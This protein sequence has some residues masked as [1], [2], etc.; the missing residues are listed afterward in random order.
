[1]VVVSVYC[2]LNPAYYSSLTICGVQRARNRFRGKQKKSFPTLY[3][4][5]T[6][7]TNIFWIVDECSST[8]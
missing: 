8:S 4:S 7:F 3:S 6:S 2:Q 5:P 1:M